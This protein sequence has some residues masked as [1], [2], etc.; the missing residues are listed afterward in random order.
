M[1]AASEWF[2]IPA[3]SANN[4]RT[5]HELGKPPTYRYDGPIIDAHCHFGSPAPTA[6]MIRAGALY[7]VTRWM[8]IC[9]IN[10]VPPI[11]RRLGRR[12]GFSIWTL[13]EKPE[14]DAAFTRANVEIVGRAAR[15]G[16]HCIKFWYKPEF[17]ERS[18]L[19][20]DDPRLDPVFAAIVEADLAVLVHIAD[21]DIWWTHRYH[22]PARFEA[23]RFTY[24]QLTNTLGRFPTMRVLVAHMGGWPENLGFLDDLLARYP[25]VRM[26]TSGTKWIARELSHRPAAARSFFIRRADRLLF[27]SDLVAFKHATFE[28]HCSR[29]WVH[30]HLYERAEPVISPIDDPDANDSVFVAGLDLPDGVLQ[31]IYLD[32]ARQFFR[33]RDPA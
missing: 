2:D 15:S 1:Q 6:R 32:N 14:D 27:G 22:D 24:R 33:L 16:C 29:Y 9:R 5:M 7:G 19:F 21:P 26:D 13:H 25:N 18:G 30:R 12:A 17:N 10:D 8:G 4:P 28:H 3:R 11:R 31:K 20:F 23:K